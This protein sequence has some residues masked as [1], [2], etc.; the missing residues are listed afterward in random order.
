MDVLSRGDAPVWYGV[1]PLALAGGVSRFPEGPKARR[2][3]SLGQ[4]PR[5]TSEN[6][7]WRAN[8]PPHR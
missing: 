8:G 3:T 1:E 6:N 7:G 5:I 2:Y 4:R